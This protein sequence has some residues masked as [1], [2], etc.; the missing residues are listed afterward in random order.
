MTD[1]PLHLALLSLHSSPLGALGTPDTGGMS[2]YLR[3]L[4]VELGCRGHRVD[5]F[6][7]APAGSG[8]AAPP[9]VALGPGARLVYLE[10][11]GGPAKLDLHPHLPELADALEGFR[12]RQALAYDLVH[13]HYWLSGLLGERVRRRWG[14]P[15]AVTF[16]TLAAVKNGAGCGENEP[17]LRVAGEAELARC[18]D[19]VIAPT[20]AEKRNLVRHCG[21]PAH[22]V[23]VIPCGVDL[24]RFRPADR[25]AARQS[26]GLGDGE[27]VLL[28][29]GRLAP[30]KGLE[31]LFAALPL[32]RH[33]P[34]PR[35]LVVGGDPAGAEAAARRA[36]E[37]GVGERVAFAGAVDQ[38][39][40]PRHYA[41][42]DLVV[43]PSA[44][45]SF[46][47]VALEA[48]ACG[49]PVAATPVGAA[50]RVIAGPDQ[51]EVAA[52]FDPGDLAR[53]ID[54]ALARRRAPAAA[55]RA[56]VAEYGWPRVADALEAEYR[57]LVG[58]AR[59]AAGG[60]P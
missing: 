13:S 5:V 39:D 23:A 29:V 50:D 2:V 12:R 45:E 59:A 10:G 48:L 57:E 15:H 16:H 47:L 11:A 32:V 17:A 3:E 31:R 24:G 28:Y 58:P 54:A 19:R 43:V 26:L 40:L 22:R 6:T 60:R 51:G 42:V 38:A 46:R 4:A 20:E 53:A 18:C 34:A 36:R 56:A 14:V 44:Y 7:R 49:T 33:R 55:V 8:G 30:V 21:A 9:P 52:G 25:A 27:T 1:H 35:L 37:L 41:A